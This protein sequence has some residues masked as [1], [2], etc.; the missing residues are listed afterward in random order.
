MSLYKHYEILSLKVEVE[1]CPGSSTN[2]LGQVSCYFDTDPTTPASSKDIV[3]GGWHNETR[4]INAY[5]PSVKY[6]KYVNVS[7]ELTQTPGEDCLKGTIDTNPLN[8]LYMKIFAGNPG[9]FSWNC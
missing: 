2:I 6:S 3:N 5:T 9:A 1:Y 7:K 4:C 8:V